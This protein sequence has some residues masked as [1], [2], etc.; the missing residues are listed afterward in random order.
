MVFPKV[1]VVFLAVSGFSLTSVTFF[2][3]LSLFFRLSRSGLFNMTTLL[4]A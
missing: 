2:L 3:G 4:F 1:T